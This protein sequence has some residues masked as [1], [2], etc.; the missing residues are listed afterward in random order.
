MT[1]VVNISKELHSKVKMAAAKAGI[2]MQEFA[3]IALEKELAKRN[4][5]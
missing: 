2:S 4:D 1:R 5:K 3:R